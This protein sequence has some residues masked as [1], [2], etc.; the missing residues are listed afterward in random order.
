MRARRAVLYMPGFDCHK[1]EKG[2][3]LGVDSIC[4]DLEDSVSAGR[5]DEARQT[6]A[7]ALQTLDFGRSERL[8]R[9]NAVSSGLAEDD[10]AAVLP[11]RPDG[12]V[13]PKV[14]SAQSLQWVS[15]QIAAAEEEYDWPAGSI[16]LLGII[17]TPLAILHLES[18]CQADK[19]L[20]ALLLGA[21][22]LAAGLGAVRTPE[23]WEVFYARSALVLYTA[24]FEL[25]AI[26][27]VCTDFKNLTALRDETRRAVQMGFSGKQVIHPAQV[28]VVQEIFT[29]DA[30]AIAQAQRLAAAF[31]EQEKQGNAVFVVDGRAVELPNLR[32]AEGVLAR[33][34]AAGKVA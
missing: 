27:M 24:A 2:I 12:I 4:M 1:I 7:Q 31:A 26:D 20:E 23:A 9:I 3:H 5:K 14:D 18:I 8:V 25:Q 13:T 6:V 10:L 34:R 29:P 16:A 22:D 33:A 30:E 32:A 15:R 21:E 28:E 11:A 19:R 17:E